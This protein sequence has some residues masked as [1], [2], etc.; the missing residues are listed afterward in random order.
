LKDNP[1]QQHDF[2]DDEGLVVE[3][4]RRANELALPDAAPLYAE[5]FGIPVF[6]CVPGEKNPLVEGGLYAATRDLGQIESWWGR[7]PDA[8]I[9]LRTGAASGYVVPRA[10]RAVSR[11]SRSMSEC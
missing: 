4:L 10:A 1:T 7:W 6:P 8:N 11:S 9:A 2:E 5:A 3:I